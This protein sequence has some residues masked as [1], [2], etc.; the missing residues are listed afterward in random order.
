M[1]ICLQGVSETGGRYGTR[2]FRSEI[3]LAFSTVGK[4]TFAA[5][6]AHDAIDFISLPYKYELDRFEQEEG[7]KGPEEIKGT[8]TLEYMRDQ[9]P[10][11]YVDAIAEEQERGEYRYILVPSDR[12]VATYLFGMG[13]PF[14]LVRPEPSLR[15][16]YKQRFTDRGNGEEFLDIFIGDW[17]TF[18]KALQMTAKLAKRDIVLGSGEYLGDVLSCFK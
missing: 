12:G 13:V 18:M 16:E 14:T 6:P 11:N 2:E 8:I 5:D 7:A 1:Y 3:V 4:T 17:D 9:W 15:D 10:C